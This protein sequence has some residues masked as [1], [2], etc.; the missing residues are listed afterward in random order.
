MPTSEP[1]RDQHHLPGPR[2]PYVVVPRYRDHIPPICHTTQ[3]QDALS[4][5]FPPQDYQNN[6]QA[7]SQYLRLRA[8]TWDIVS[9]AAM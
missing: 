5:H 7:I 8:W 9:A 6:D 2:D 3:F 1:A 4:T